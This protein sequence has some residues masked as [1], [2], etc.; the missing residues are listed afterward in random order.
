MTNLWNKNKA[1]IIAMF[2]IAI[3]ITIQ[4]LISSSLNLI[5]N[6]MIG[7]LNETA[8]AAVAIPNQ[9]FFLF[10]LIAF[11]V[12][13]GT[14]IF[15]SQFWG[16]KDSYNIKRVLGIAIFT[17]SLVA[18]LFTVLS[19]T[20]PEFIIS[21]FV[22]D[23]EVINLGSKYL[24][25][26]SLSFILTAIGFSY[27]FAS[28]S[29]GRAKLPMIAS[30][31]ALS[32]N[33]VLNYLLIF[34]KFGFPSLGV[35]GA[36]IATLIS[37]IIELIIIVGYIY[38]KDKIL[39]AKLREMLDLNKVFISK[40]FK[41]TK[42][43]ILNEAFWALGMTMYMVAYGTIGKKAVTSVH[44][45]NTIQNLFMVVSMGLGNACAVMIGNKLGA[46]EEKEA[47]SY[48]KKFSFLG[49]TVGISIGLILILLSPIVLKFF[50]ISSEV[51]SDSLKV[52]IIMGIFMVFK[53]FNTVLIV[54]ILRS[55]GDTTYSLML[56]IGSVWAIGVPLSFIGA[57]LLKL[58]IYWVITLVHLEEIVKAV[59]GL[60]RIISKKWVK[61][62]VNDI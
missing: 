39:N 33:T 38:T 18:F 21:L 62:I 55:G 60:K 42:P 14:G 52:L 58:P 37:R 7:K 44:I 34:G 35:E 13:S 54:G 31:I 47:I 51:Y 36:A 61:N 26:V 32:T 12:N 30:I 15:I 10:V 8:I 3:P 23:L 24:K 6:L 56:E 11:G 1:F 25:I 46:S 9:V 53:V 2:S 27:S 29:I 49:I 28:R 40:F 17:G 16:K 19:L 50:N 45:S 4:N 20:I 57:T 59:I 22:D 5:D 41:T 43:V 48:A